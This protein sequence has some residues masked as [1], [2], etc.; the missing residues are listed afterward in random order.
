MFTSRV[1][2]A[3]VLEALVGAVAWVR[4]ATSLRHVEEVMEVLN[5]RDTVTYLPK[6]RSSRKTGTGTG[7]TADGTAE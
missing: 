4:R 1:T 2:A 3:A 5:R 7:P 6:R